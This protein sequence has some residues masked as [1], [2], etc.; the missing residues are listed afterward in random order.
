MKVGDLVELSAYGK[1]LKCFSR[2]RGHRGIILK[3]LHEYSIWKVHWF[4]KT[5]SNTMS[6]KD[7]KHLKAK[8]NRHTKD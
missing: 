5:F 8:K 1:K 7:I 4:D 3:R 2:L 6:R